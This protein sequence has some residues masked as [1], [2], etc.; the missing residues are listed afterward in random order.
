MQTERRSAPRQGLNSLVYL[1]LEPDNGGIL[2][3]LSETGMQ[4]SVA[5]RLVTSS[6]IRFTLRLDPNETISGTG[7]V[8]WLS[9]SGRSAGVHFLSLPEEARREIRQWMGVGADSSSAE[10]DEDHPEPAAE[11][12]QA[13]APSAVAPASEPTPAIESA[14]A[15]TVAPEAEAPPSPP[16]ETPRIESPAPSEVPEMQPAPEPATETGMLEVLATEPAD[17]LELLGA[18]VEAREI[19]DA[20]NTWNPA[21]I[22]PAEP[23]LDG[24]GEPSSV[25]SLYGIDGHE[26]TEFKS[27]PEPSREETTDR[28]PIAAAG[29][30]Q[31]WTADLPSYR[32]RPTAESERPGLR[33]PDDRAGSSKARRARA[34]ARRQQAAHKRPPILLSPIFVPAPPPSEFLPPPDPDKLYKP[35]SAPVETPLTDQTPAEP[36]QTA[37]SVFPASLPEPPAEHSSSQSGALYLP[38][39]RID[40]VA[41]PEPPPHSWRDFF[42]KPIPQFSDFFERFEEFGWSLESDWH[43]WLS[44]I[45]LLAGFLSLAQNPPLIVLTIAFWFA[46][47]VVISDR[48]RPRHGKRQ[49]QKAGHR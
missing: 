42:R 11:P 4:I 29:Y 21:A 22:A 39:Y 12:P 18:T 37:A 13:E 31:S 44:L 26:E 5:N 47:A 49:R 8:A 38:N 19:E 20:P 41:P 6:E 40:L 7:R 1:D 34:R 10:P 33:T 16:A 23:A 46:S 3:N 30:P 17:A 9:P 27:R 24:D 2:L 35:V 14:A 15:E 32:F 48:R 28:Q 45:L 36:A 25:L 43:V